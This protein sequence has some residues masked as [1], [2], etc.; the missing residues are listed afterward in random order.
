MGSRLSLLIGDRR[1]SVVGL[2]LLSIASGFTEAGILVLI[3]QVAATLVTGAKV[4]HAH[5]GPLQVHTG[6][7]TLIGIAFALTIIRIFI[8][9]P[10]S[11]LGARIAADVQAGLRT[12]L[13]EAFSRASWEVQSQDREGQLQETMTSQVMQATVGAQQTTLMI[14]AVFSFLVLMVSRLW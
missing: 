5:I 13:F 3:A 7:G 9:V 11:F 12:R 1:G 2:S 8:Q 6:L 14:N 4:L 10:L